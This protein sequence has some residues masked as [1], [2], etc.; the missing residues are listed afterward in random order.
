MPRPR[1]STKSPKITKPKNTIP[2]IPEQPPVYQAAP[3]NKTNTL[4]LV[5]LL[6][7]IVFAGY[8][9]IKV[10]NLEKTVKTNATQAATGQQQPAQKITLDQVKALFKSGFMYFGNTDKKVLLVE[11]TDPSCPFCHVAGGLDPETSKSINTQFQYKDDGGS[12]VPPVPEMRKLVDQGKASMV[13]L[14]SP[15]HGNGEIAAQALYCAYAQGKFW[16][17]HDKLMSGDGY[18]VINNQVLND[19]TKIPILVNFLSDAIDSNYLSS[20]LTSGKYSDALKRD[21]QVSQALG[22]QGTPYFIINTTPYA[23]AYPWSQMSSSVNQ[24]LG[25]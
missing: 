1:K 4:M 10:Q 23:G 6:A 22:Y 21:E 20:C 14:Y 12:Y 13:F 15:G 7:V 9:F 18:N 16:Q 24:A 3:A 8:L 19:K 5:L 25:S 2:E 17:V 11:V